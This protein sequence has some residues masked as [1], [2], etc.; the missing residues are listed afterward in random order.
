MLAFGMLVP[1][2]PLLRLGLRH[3]LRNLPH[4]PTTNSSANAKSNP[5]PKVCPAASSTKSRRKPSPPPPANNLLPKFLSRLILSFVLPVDFGCRFCFLRCYASLASSANIEPHARTP[6]KNHRARR[7]RFPP[8]RRTTH[9]Q[10][11]S[12][13]QR[14]NHS[15]TGQQNFAQFAARNAG[16]RLSSRKSRILGVRRGFSNQRRRLCRRHAQTLGKY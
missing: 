8:P 7:H 4:P 10:R 9:S 13:R 11:T 14:K 2:V 15:R 12:P 6:A 5:R 3:R 16:A 1:P